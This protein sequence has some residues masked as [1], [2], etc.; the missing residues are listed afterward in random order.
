MDFEQDKIILGRQ[1][2]ILEEDFEVLKN[3]IKTL[4]ERATGGEIDSIVFKKEVCVEINSMRRNLVNVISA[5]KSLTN[6]SF[7]HSKAINSHTRTINTLSG[8]DHLNK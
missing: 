5:I 4:D 7:S 1:V 6:G 8:N 2:K 3:R